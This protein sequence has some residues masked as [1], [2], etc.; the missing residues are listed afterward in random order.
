MS[1]TPKINM[2]LN[3]AKMHFSLNLE[4]LTSIGA[5]LWRR[6]FQTGGKF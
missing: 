5:K 4:I 3:S 1:I 2:D 6:Q